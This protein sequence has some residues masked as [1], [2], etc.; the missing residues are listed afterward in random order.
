[1]ISWSTSDVAGVNF[2]DS[3]ITVARVRGQ[4]GGGMEVTHAGWNTYDPGASDESIAAAVKALWRKTRLPTTT[5]VA[6]LRSA[7]TR[8]RPAPAPP[9]RPRSPR[10]FPR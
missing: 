8:A 1:M 4:M 6:S 3:H 7:A 9:R 10:P 5:V 2:G